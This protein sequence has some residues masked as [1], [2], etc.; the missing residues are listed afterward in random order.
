VHLI[1]STQTSQ[2]EEDVRAK[3]NTSKMSNSVPF[4]VIVDTEIIAPGGIVE[5]GR[6]IR[7]RLASCEDWKRAAWSS[8]WG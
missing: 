8:V 1:P 7:K 4:V 2:T 6:G 5:P 3:Y